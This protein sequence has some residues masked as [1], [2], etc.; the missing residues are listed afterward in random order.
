[1]TKN[2]NRGKLA[3]TNTNLVYRIFIFSFLSV[4]FLSFLNYIVLPSE[5]YNSVFNKPWPPR[6]IAPLGVKVT[7]PKILPKNCNHSTDECWHQSV[8]RGKVK[9]VATGVVDST[10][11]EIVF[12]YFRNT[13]TSFG[14][15]GLYNYLPF[16]K[17][18]GSRVLNDISGG[19]GSEIDWVVGTATG[20]KYHEKPTNTCYEY[21]YIKDVASWRNKKLTC[22]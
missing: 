14:V 8:A 22:E 1:M 11:R 9:F 6:H 13:S 7:D 3:K 16:Y 15:T 19:N 4:G 20:I 12:A 10:G 5:L 17:D 18:D 21:Y 2:S